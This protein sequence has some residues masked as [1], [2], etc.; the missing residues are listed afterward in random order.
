[1]S[2]RRGALVFLLSSS[3]VVSLVCQARV[4]AAGRQAATAAPQMRGTG[5][6]GLVEDALGG[7]IAGALVRATCGDVVREVRTDTAGRFVLGGLPHVPCRVRASADLFTPIAHEV[8]LS[9]GRDAQVR[10]VVELAGIA[11]EVVVTPARGEQERTFDVP[12]AVGITTREELES[13]PVRI[14]PQALQEET[15][16]LVQ[17]T[18]TAQGSPFIRGFSA[19]R[20]V[21][22]LDGV[23][24]NTST[25][26]AGATQ[27][28][29]WID[30]ASIQR[31]EIVRGPSSV[32][33]GSD[34][35]GGTVNVLTQRPDV[36]PAGTQASGQLEVEAATADLGAGIHAFGQARTTRFALRG[37]ASTRA[38]G[39]LRPGNG[40]DSHS[41]LT[42][43]LGLPSTASY[44][45]LPGTG[46]RQAGW[47]L[48]GTLPF[49]DGSALTG[50]VMREAQHGV[51]RYDR[52]VGGDGLYRS[53][54]D[55]QRL[56]FGYVRYQRGATGPFAAVQGTVSLNT[57][58]D[59]RLEQA[60]PDAFIETETSTVRALGYAAQGT[61][62]PW[63]GHVV[64][65][66]A[67][68]YDESIATGRAR[69]LHGN[70]SWLRPEIPD[71]ASYT[72]A[73]VFAQDSASLLS[74]RLAFRVGTR[75]ATFLYDVPA[76]VEH[77]VNAER[78]RMGAVTFNTGAVWRVNEAL[79]V[80]G[81]ISRG[82]RAA[83]AFDLGA[84]GVSGGG[85]EGAPQEAAARGALI[86][87]DDGAR[88]ASTGMP[89]T[90]LRP[91]TVY[92]FEVGA[93]LRT[94]RVAA[95]V[96]GF[97]LELRDLI[98]RRTA[99]FPAGIV[100]TSFGGYAVVAQDAQGRAYVSADTRPIVTR[101]NVERA[102]V[103]GF[104][105]DTQARL[106]PSWIAAAH[107]SLANGRDAD[108]MYLRRMPPL[109]AGLRLKWEPAVQPFW[110]EVV[111]TAAARQARLSPGDLSDARIGGRRRRADIA[112]FFSGTATDIGLV[113]DGRL[114][115]TGE[116]LDDVQA[117]LLG[118]AS[119][120][121]L[122]TSTPGFVVFSLRG[123]WRL[124]SR[125]D[126]T[127]LAEN[128]TDRNHR[129]H[130]SG[131]DAPGFSLV[132]KLRIR[133]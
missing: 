128:L 69:R 63:R 95:S 60:R 14:L 40:I 106:A 54:F 35:L 15:G 98:A 123:G 18:T 114:A 56:A 41:A 116:D 92:A 122:F 57:Q 110:A 24:F 84:I 113:T 3:I 78:V 89:V 37:G 90:A 58:Q 79:N 62:A 132:A 131:V 30:P 125:L 19:Q 97:D 26:R 65:A 99:I 5:I 118:G 100:G 129:W 20:V 108:G 109:M 130:G 59:D 1:M 17:Q 13:R 101:V 77:G 48:A 107:V 86:G 23:R 34:A 103:Q 51:N 102:R 8:D 11:S 67:E 31:L 80:T 105:A 93:K 50:L 104:E 7:A 117:R 124:T 111:V 83:N 133:L 66:G 21:Y 112:A 52:V 74:H 126:A 64:T 39:D 88:A 70:A 49:G 94:R 44:G 87:T 71:G 45:R 115:A 4:G 27:Y 28:L 76:D 81:S 10:F 72:S 75:A 119:E 120:T 9:A 121:Y 61:L 42:R 16:I 2:T 12:E 32:Q 85:F 127:V 38:A 53:V 68:V 22:L 43:Y 29:G 73:G 33:Y 55:P 91:E 47:S 82:F 6:S 46:Y 36:V 96:V 25:Y